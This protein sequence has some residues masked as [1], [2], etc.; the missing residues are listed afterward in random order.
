MCRQKAGSFLRA[1][2]EVVVVVARHVRR[3]TSHGAGKLFQSRSGRT[4]SRRRGKQ[5]VQF[6]IHLFE[7]PAIQLW[8][9][10]NDFLRA[11]IVKMPCFSEAVKLLRTLPRFRS[12]ASLR[13]SLF[14]EHID[15]PYS[16]R[17]ATS[18]KACVPNPELGTVQSHKRSGL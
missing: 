13:I 9:F 6:R 1:S 8:Q 2:V 17:S 11:H 7:F 16:Y 5:L 10:R 14:L 15:F 12:V 4:G 3:Q 18:L